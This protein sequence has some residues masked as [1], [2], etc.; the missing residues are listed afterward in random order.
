MPDE[1]AISKYDRD[2]YAYRDTE[3]HRGTYHLESCYV[4]TFAFW[5]GKYYGLIEEDDNQ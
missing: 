3:N 5:L 2:P 4:Y 1:R